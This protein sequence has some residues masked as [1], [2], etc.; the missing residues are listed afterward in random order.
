[1]KLPFPSF[2]GVG[3]PKRGVID[4]PSNSSLPSSSAKIR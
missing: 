4:R 1:V 2:T 3:A